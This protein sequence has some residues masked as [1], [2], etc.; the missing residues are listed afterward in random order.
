MLSLVHIQLSAKLW[1]EGS[2]NP[3]VLEHAKKDHVN[4]THNLFRLP[5][6]GSTSLYNAVMRD[7]ALHRHVCW[8]E[9]HKTDGHAWHMRPPPKPQKPVLLSLR[10]PTELLRSH[11]EY[12]GYLSN[13]TKAVPARV[14]RTMEW[15]SSRQKA[16]QDI[17][18]CLGQDNPPVHQQLRVYFHDDRIREIPDENHNTRI[19]FIKTNNLPLHAFVHPAD[20]HVWKSYCT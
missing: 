3:S 15:I 16:P 9:A 8:L 14:V 4:C 10:E 12:E 13:S 1:N 5:K 19:R 7:P 17:Y 6:T 2:K 11:L 18:L 20:R